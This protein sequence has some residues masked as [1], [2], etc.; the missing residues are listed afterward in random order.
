LPVGF[1][2]D[3]FQ[4]GESGTDPAALIHAMN[5]RLTTVHLADHAPG[6]PRHLPPGEGA[7]DWHAI[8]RALQTAGYTGPLIL[9]P[10]HVKDPA[11]LLRARDFMQQALTSATL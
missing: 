11:T 4:A 9:E 8:L 5:S 10:A 2:F 6:S 3:T 7:L 1:T